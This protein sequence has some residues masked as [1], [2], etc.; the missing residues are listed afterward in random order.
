MT[1]TNETHRTST[2]SRVAVPRPWLL[3]VS[4][5]GFLV[6]YLASDLVVASLASAPLPLRFV[7]VPAVGQ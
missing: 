4:A 2:G 5:A 6:L 3:I 1:S 7:R